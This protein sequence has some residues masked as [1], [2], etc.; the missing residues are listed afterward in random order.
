[1]GVHQGNLVMTRRLVAGESQE[2]AGIVHPLVDV[3]VIT[4][5]AGRTLVNTNEI[6]HQQTNDQCREQPHK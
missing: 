1:M 4:E 3:H 6:V 2:V 5:D